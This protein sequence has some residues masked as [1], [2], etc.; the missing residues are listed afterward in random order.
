MPSCAVVLSVWP[1][2]VCQT[3]CV[4]QVRIPFMFYSTEITNSYG[5]TRSE[6]WCA[7]AAHT[8]RLRFRGDRREQ[9]RNL[10]EPGPTARLCRTSGDTGVHL[11]LPALRLS[12]FCDHHHRLCAG[13]VRCGTQDA[14][15]LYQP[16]PQSPDQPRGCRQHDS[17]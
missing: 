3:T 4:Q 9:V 16:V 2:E 6:E 1:A 11:S 13:A 7:C 14:Q 12:R 8:R 10:A 5:S 15:A 17:G